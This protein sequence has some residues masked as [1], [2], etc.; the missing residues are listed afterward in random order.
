MIQCR[1][2]QRSINKRD[3]LEYRSKSN[4]HRRIETLD[5][6]NR[7]WSGPPS[8]TENQSDKETSIRPYIFIATLLFLALTSYWVSSFV[9]IFFVFYWLVTLEF[10][11]H[12]CNRQHAID[13][14]IRSKFT[15][16]YSIDSNSHS[17][18][19]QMDRKK[20]SQLQSRYDLSIM[21]MFQIKPIRL[22]PHLFGLAFRHVRHSS[23]LSKK[24]YLWHFYTCWFES[25]WSY[26]RKMSIKSRE[27]NELSTSFNCM[28]LTNLVS[29]DCRSIGSILAACI[30]LELQ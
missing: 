21:V 26:G 19:S 29:W 25:V 27:C 28:S 4:C 13:L 16:S 24:S 12:E 22:I 14:H 1:V 10:A 23:C 11:T 17:P 6:C 30:D 2:N 9:D 7:T 3:Q 18:V 5:Y 8:T 15:D 20:T